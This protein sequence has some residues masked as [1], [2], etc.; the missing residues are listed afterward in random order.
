MTLWIVRAGRY[1]EREPTALD[2]NLVTI[3]WDGFPN[4]TSVKSRDELK[5]LMEESYPNQKKMTIANY[6]GQVWAF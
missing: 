3:G 1:S 6:T 4:L 5:Q 2:K